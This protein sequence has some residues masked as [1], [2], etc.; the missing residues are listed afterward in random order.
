[1]DS[2]KT[3]QIVRMEKQ[4]LPTLAGLE[5]LCFSQ[6]WSELAF[7]EELNNPIAYFIVAE[8]ETGEV[9]GYAG[10]QHVA[11]EGYIANI[12]VSPGMRRRGVASLLL[13]TFDEYARANKLSLLTLEVR[14][15]N[16]AAIAAYEKAEFKKVGLRPHFYSEPDEDALIMTKCYID[17]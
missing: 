10:M 7:E 3:I 5:R 12:A 4:H 2:E 17:N 15:S 6:P 14:A 8:T 16:Q 13:S 9:A 1:M 11:G